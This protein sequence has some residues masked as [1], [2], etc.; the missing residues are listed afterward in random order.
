ML[1]IIYALYL[2]STPKAMELIRLLDF[3]ITVYNML[4]KRHNNL[5]FT[6]HINWSVIK[7]EFSASSKYSAE[8][9]RAH[10]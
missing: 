5:H 6:T 10:V 1:I 3:D 8:I 9:G 7:F 2:G 4:N